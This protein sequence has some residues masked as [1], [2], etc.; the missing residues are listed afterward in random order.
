MAL[1]ISHCLSRAMSIDILSRSIPIHTYPIHRLPPGFK[2]PVQSR[3]LPWLAWH[4][5]WLLF[6]WL[7]VSTA[8]LTRKCKFR[9][10]ASSEANFSL[11]GGRGIFLLTIASCRYHHLFH[12]VALELFVPSKG[13][14]PVDLSCL[15]VSCVPQSKYGMST[16]NKN[17]GVKDAPP[18]AT[19]LLPISAH[20]P[21]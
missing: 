19:Y 4:W 9:P 21:H 16:K 1:T 7:K 3:I 17:K 10:A 8:C 2:S 13:L 11:W 6:S 20:R 15:P 5:L 18:R 14:S 12:T